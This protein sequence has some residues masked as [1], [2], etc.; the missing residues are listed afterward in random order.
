MDEINPYLV[1]LPGG[2]NNTMN[3]KERVDLDIDTPQW[4]LSEWKKFIDRLILEHGD[5]ATL[6][7][8]GGHNNVCLYISK[9]T[10]LD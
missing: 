10:N 6:G 4:T 5:H 3:Q 8:D 7:T 2:V 1:C 9:L